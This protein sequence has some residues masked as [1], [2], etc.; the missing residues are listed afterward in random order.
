MFE[1][2]RDTGVGAWLKTKPLGARTNQM[3]RKC[4]IAPP[5]VNSL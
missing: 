2:V 4:C 3:I 1:K 5:R